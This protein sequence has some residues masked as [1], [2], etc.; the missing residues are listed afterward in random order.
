MK[1]LVLITLFMTFVA[2]SAERPRSFFYPGSVSSE[3]ARRDSLKTYIPPGSISYVVSPTKPLY[4]KWELKPMIAIPL[5]KFT[6]STSEDGAL[7]ATFITSSGTGVTYQKTEIVD[8]KFNAKYSVSGFFLVSGSLND[9]N[10]SI[11]TAVCATFGVWNNR[12]QFGAGYDLGKVSGR[13]RFFGLA[14][15]GINLT[16]N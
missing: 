4:P 2:L 12:I 14:S 15:L 10:L 3:L 13:S 7:D 9:S 11:D 5:L 1:A 6:E 8:D 16:N